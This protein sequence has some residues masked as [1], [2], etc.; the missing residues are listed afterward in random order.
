MRW[1]ERGPSVCVSSWVERE[2]ERGGKEREKTSFQ[3]TGYIFLSNAIICPRLWGRLGDVA[4]CI[5]RCRASHSPGSSWRRAPRRG[6]GRRP[7]ASRGRNPSSKWPNAKSA[8]PFYFSTCAH[9]PRCEFRV[10]RPTEPI[11]PGVE[12]D[13]YAAALALMQRALPLCE[14]YTAGWIAYFAQ[15]NEPLMAGTVFQ[16]EASYTRVS[17]RVVGV[18]GLFNPAF[19]TFHPHNRNSRQSTNTHSA[20]GGRT[21]IGDT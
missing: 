7:P 19:H 8:R 6:W 17:P 18:D 2:R 11:L 21:T 4:P 16:N 15:S 20:R 10:R 14:C 3:P 1:R 9:P 13:I 5:S 12:R